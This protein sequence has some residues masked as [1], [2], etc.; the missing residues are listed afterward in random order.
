EAGAGF[1]RRPAPQTA[2]PTQPGPEN[3]TRR[4][5]DPRWW[6]FLVTLCLKWGR[7]GVPPP[8][9]RANTMRTA[10]GFPALCLLLNLHAAGCF[11]RNN[12]QFLAIHQKKS[13]K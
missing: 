10:V 6:L 7:G 3:E 9:L 12:D 5:E 11:S 8:P 4:P 1:C 13:G 2:L